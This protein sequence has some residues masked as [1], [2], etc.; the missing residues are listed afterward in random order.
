MDRDAEGMAEECHRVEGYGYSCTARLDLQLDDPVLCEGYEGLPRVGPA[1]HVPS[2]A[3]LPQ[4][5]GDEFIRLQLL[6]VCLL[7]AKYFR[8]ISLYDKRSI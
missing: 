5:T 8:N 6:L 4:K 1:H 3:M 2:L 7:I